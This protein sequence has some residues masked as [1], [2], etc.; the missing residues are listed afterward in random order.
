MKQLL[1]LLTILLGLTADSAAQNGSKATSKPVIVVGKVLSS[2]D[3]TYVKQLFFEAISFKYTE[4]VD[5]S[6]KKF[7]AVI[8]IDPANDAAL[9]ELANIYHDHGEEA[10][11]ES[12]IRRA[13]TV[14]PDNIWYWTLLADIYKK[15]NNFKDA[16][17]VF[18]QLINLSAD[19]EEYYYDKASALLNLK[20]T[21]EALLVY[22][23]IENR[24]GSS[25]DLSL[26]R[27]Q[28]FVQQGKP[29][30][31]VSELLKQITQSPNEVRNY[32]YLSEIYGKNKEWDKSI[33]ILLKA[34][35]V[36]PE[37]AMVR[38][39]LADHY[40]SINQFD[41]SFIEL[42]EAFKDY[43]LNVDEKVRI[44]LSFFPL[45][46]DI[47]A[48]AYAE[49]LSKIATNIHPEDP[50]VFAVY[51]DVLFQ[52][53]K[54]PQAA[55]VYR[56]AL[57]LNSQVY[58]IWEQLVRI[59]VSVSDF[60]QAI[61]D[62]DEALEIFPNQAAL[63]LYTGI[64]YAQIQKHDKAITYFK[65]AANLET[66]NSDVLGQIYSSLGDSYNAVKK[67]KESDVSYEKSL[68]YLP[69]NSYTLNNYAYYLSLRG[70]KLDKAEIMSRRSN[71]LVPNNA[72][73]QDTYAWILFKLKRFDEAKVWIEKAIEN[74]KNSS[75]VQI[76]HYG[77]ILYSV[78]EKE[79]AIGQWVKA[80]AGGAKSIN[81]DRK[82]NE[83]K[84][85]E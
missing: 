32:L 84:Y 5:E 68:E 23:E 35:T 2:A 28:I 80:K 13:V 29:E 75:P 54:Y 77:D 9:Y 51:G 50:K 18:D 66:E 69:N 45:F 15:A 20:K 27:E 37:N 16:I 73:S 4:N 57:K 6:S 48:R 49:E 42:K 38:L 30:K 71:E 53:Q 25:N 19:V 55:E 52:Q 7:H 14:K 59:D 41:N 61:K 83:K 39:S 33:E 34:K 3:S 44:V 60:K 17:P 67:Y 82:I 8:N 36:A 58:Q 31:A 43:N 21:K 78:G 72:S 11:A 85:I 26:A 24:F 10:D 81:L 22:Q 47:K 64:A 12:F 56:T 76:E 46:S 63:H 79:K 1:F 70:D 40:R 65:N 74:D 62:G